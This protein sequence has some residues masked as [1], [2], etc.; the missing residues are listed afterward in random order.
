MLKKKLHSNDID[1]AQSYENSRRENKNRLDLT[2]TYIRCT[3]RYI[4]I[5]AYNIYMYS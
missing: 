4:L 3:G 1:R 2:R 5:Q